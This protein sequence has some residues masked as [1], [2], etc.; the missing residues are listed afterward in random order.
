VAPWINLAYES[1]TDFFDFD[2][3][4]TTIKRTNKLAI[5]ESDNDSEGVQNSVNF[6]K[7]KFPTAQVKTFHN[8]GH[9]TFNSMKTVEFPELLEAILQ[10]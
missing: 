10:P 3:D 7:Q 1:D 6:I 2:I 4:P 9:F 8:Y 5:I